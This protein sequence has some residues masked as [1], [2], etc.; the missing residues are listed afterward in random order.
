MNSIRWRLQFD[1]E[2]TIQDNKGNEDEQTSLT[3]YS[4]NI[5]I[6]TNGRKNVDDV[7]EGVHAQPS[8]YTFYFNDNVV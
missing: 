2:E 5:T 8:N 4:Y 1:E 6:Q 7:A 3:F